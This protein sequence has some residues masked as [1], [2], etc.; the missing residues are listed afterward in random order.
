MRAG[1]AAPAQMAL[2]DAQQ[3]MQHGAESS[4]PKYER[5]GGWATNVAQSVAPCWGT[6]RLYIE[7]PEMPMGRRP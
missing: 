6:S 3:D 2:D 7:R 5:S 4:R 1:A